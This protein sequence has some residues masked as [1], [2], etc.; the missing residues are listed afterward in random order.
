[1]GGSCSSHKKPK[2]SDSLNSFESVDHLS[3]NNSFSLPSDDPM[4]DFRQELQK[5]QSIVRQESL[6]RYQPAQRLQTPA[7]SENT[8]VKKFIALYDYEAR[9]SGEISFLK[10]EHFEMLTDAVST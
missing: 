5:Q 8:N 4:A 7:E 1:M 3:R 6:S 2:R 10:G 9:T